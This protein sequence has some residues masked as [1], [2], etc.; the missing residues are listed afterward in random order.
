MDSYNRVIITTHCGEVDLKNHFHHVREFYAVGIV[1]H[2]DD[3]LQVQ[4][5]MVF[6][7]AGAIHWNQ[8]LQID[9]SWCIST[10]D[11][12]C[13]E[14]T[15]WTRDGKVRRFMLHATSWWKHQGKFNVE[16]KVDHT[17][18]ACP[19]W[20]VGCFYPE[21]SDHRFK[22]YHMGLDGTSF[23]FRDAQGDDFW[24]NYNA[25][26]ELKGVRGMFV[27]MIIVPHQRLFYTG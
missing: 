12:G 25:E 21:S 22:W 7:Q 20:H 3:A 14:A 16:V 6:Q 11:S 10:N 24:T 9:G 17:V 18:D 13:Y 5:V 4:D 23:T 1:A 19:W 2:G 15:E 8:R 26:T 27:F